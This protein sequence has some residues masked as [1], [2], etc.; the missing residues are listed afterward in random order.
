MFDDD[1]DQEPSSDASEECG[2]P[3][4]HTSANA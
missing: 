1:E 4:D 3:S 2:H